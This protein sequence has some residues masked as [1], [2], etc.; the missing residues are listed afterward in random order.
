VSPNK[1]AS[2]SKRLE[3]AVK[4]SLGAST[5]LPRE[6]ETQKNPLN[7]GSAIAP[8]MTRSKSNLSSEREPAT[9]KAQFFVC[10]DEF[11][12]T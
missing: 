6:Y 2:W 10:S 3:L 1:T 8:T 7:I 4:P 9:S 11:I 5:A 12:S